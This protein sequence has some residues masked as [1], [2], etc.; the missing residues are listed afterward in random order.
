MVDLLVYV[1]MGAMLVGIVLFLMS[2]NFEAKAKAIRSASIF[3]FLGG[4]IGG[5]FATPSR[6]MPNGMPGALPVSMLFIAIGVIMI[7]NALAKK[8]SGDTANE[9]KKINGKLLL[10]I[11]GVVFAIFVAMAFADS[12][13]SSSSEPWRELGVTK[14]E[15]MDVYNYYKYGNP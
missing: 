11:A 4:I 14:K 15:Y 9:K 3:L 5:C 2:A 1:S 10:I 13:S 6:G 7:V 8:S 12:P